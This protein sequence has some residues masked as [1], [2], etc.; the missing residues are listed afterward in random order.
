MALLRLSCWKI[1]TSD[2]GD[3]SQSLLD[4]SPRRNTV[5]MLWCRWGPSFQITKACQ[6][7]CE[8]ACKW[9]LSFHSWT[10]RWNPADCS[11]VTSWQTIN[12]RQKICCAQIPVP[13]PVWDILFS[14]PKFSIKLLDNSRWLIHDLYP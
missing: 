14:Q 10:F 13:Q 11:T 2:W 7:L 3:F 4:Q 9:I 5:A 8:W 1:V 6:H 12:Q